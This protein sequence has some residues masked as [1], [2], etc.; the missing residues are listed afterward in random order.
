M[1]KIMGASCVQGPFRAIIRKL[2][3]GILH[4]TIEF[5]VLLVPLQPFHGRVQ[6][7]NRSP[8]VPLEEI[9]RLI[10]SIDGTQHRQH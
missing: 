7:E 9:A 2:G 6:I 3:V 5:K 8:G 1:G 4:S 10:E